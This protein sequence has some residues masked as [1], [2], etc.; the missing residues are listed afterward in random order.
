MKIFLDSANINEIVHAAPFIDG[1]TTNPSLLPQAADPTPTIK[2]ICGIVRGPVSFEV[3]GTTANEMIKEGEKF[4]RIHPNIIVKLPMGEEG[5]LA[6][7]ALCDM[8][9]HTNVTL[10]FNVTQ[11]L[12]A[13]KSGASYVSPFIGRLEDMGYRGLG[14]LEDIMQMYKMHH[15]TTQVITAS[16]RNTNHV[17]EAA[18]RGSHIA[19]VPFKVFEQLFTHP[20]TDI[21]LEKFLLDWKKYEI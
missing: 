18:L 15:L 17:R 2:E 21:G 1:V 11:A 16:I 6:C 3:V 19:T 9:I 13:A 10:V 7:Q 20:L 4:S 8:G 12:M 14:V 5:L